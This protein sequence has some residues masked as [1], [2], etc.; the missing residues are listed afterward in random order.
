[1]RLMDPSIKTRQ[2]LWLYVGYWMKMW[3]MQSIWMLFVHLSFNIGYYNKNVL[4]S[5]SIM[6]LFKCLYVLGVGI[7]ANE[8]TLIT[9][10]CIPFHIWFNYNCNCILFSKGNILCCV[11]WFYWISFGPLANIALQFTEWSSY[12]KD[13]FSNNFWKTG[14]WLCKKRRSYFFFGSGT[15]SQIFYLYFHDH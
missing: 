1:M 13:G 7:I 4:Y 3:F 10:F 5:I 6:F 12:F 14:S 8:T 2:L 15:F 11:Y 9:P